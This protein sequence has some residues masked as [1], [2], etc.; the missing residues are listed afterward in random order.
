MDSTEPTRYPQLQE[1]L[2]VDV[3]VVGGGVAG[4]CSAWELAETGRSVALLEAD[5][6][7]A[8]VTGHATAKLSS[9][10]SLIYADLRKSFG[11]DAARQYAQSHQ[12]AVEHVSA[13]ATRLGIGLRP[14]ARARVHLHRVG[15]ARRPRCTHLGCIVRFNDAE[16]SWDYPCHGSRFATDGSVI[17]GPAN[18]PLDPRK[19]D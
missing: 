5:R 17:Q 12:E 9:L 3:A 15:R 10:H 18:R 16:R 6:I 19:L 11:A 14:G 13:V 1:D 7:V 4:V 2:T 8:A